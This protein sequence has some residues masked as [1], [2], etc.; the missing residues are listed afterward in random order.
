MA[1]PLG[2]EARSTRWTAFED[3]DRATPYRCLYANAIEELFGG[4][5]GAVPM[6][7]GE[8]EVGN[9]GHEATLEEDAW[10]SK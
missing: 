9:D 4:A 2:T 10:R 1:S 6:D 3:R 7:L 5:F 8:V